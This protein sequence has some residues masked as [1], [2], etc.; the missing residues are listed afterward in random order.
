MVAAAATKMLSIAVDA[1]DDLA[2]RCSGATATA[3]AVAGGAVTAAVVPSL[4]S[5]STGSLWGHYPRLTTR[6]MR[7]LA[8]PPPAFHSSCSILARLAEPLPPL[9]ASATA[10]AAE[11]VTD[12]L[13]MCSE[14]LMLSADVYFQESP[15]AARSIAN[16]A[17]LAAAIVAATAITVDTHRSHS[18]AT[19]CRPV[20]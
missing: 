14:S 13:Q 4:L 19:S 18:A 5:S 11:R 3:A 6:R 8:R 10:L 9:T 16:L 1:T 12:L 15:K 7:L 17:Q 2:L 20:D